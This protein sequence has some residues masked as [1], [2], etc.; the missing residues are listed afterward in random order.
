MRQHMQFYQETTKWNS[1]EVPNHIYLLN[2]SKSKMIGYVR[3]GTN[4]LT[5]FSTPMGFET[6]GRTFAKVANTFGALPTQ[7]KPAHP[8]WTVAGSK[9][10]SYTVSKIDGRFVCSCTGFKF[11]GR[12]KHATKIQGEQK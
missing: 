7:E 5:I 4:N 2:D 10:D 11:H 8:T 3:A 12:C 6:R 1:S 9:G